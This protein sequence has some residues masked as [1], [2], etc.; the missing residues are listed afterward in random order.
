MIGVYEVTGERAYRGHDPGTTFWAVLDPNAEQRAIN[1][2]SIRVIERL[3]AALPE[4]R[5]RLPIG[6]PTTEGK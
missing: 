2:G 6:W 3:A 1:R 5:Y 4:H